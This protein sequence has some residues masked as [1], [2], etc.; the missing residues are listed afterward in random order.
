MIN[1]ARTQRQSWS[2]QPVA[3]P[4]YPTDLLQLLSQLLTKKAATQ[5]TV[6]QPTSPVKAWEPVVDLIG[7]YF[8]GKGADKRQR[9][10]Q[11][12]LGNLLSQATTPVNVPL[13]G[14]GDSSDLSLKDMATGER[15]T[16]QG[17]TRQR[18]RTDQEVVALL[19]GHPAGQRVA[20]R[21]LA[22]QLE[23]RFNP[24][25][26]WV[27]VQG[28]RGTLLQ[29]NNRTGE[30]RSVV[31]QE[32]VPDWHKPGWLDAQRALLGE[33]AKVEK[34]TDAER[35]A[36]G[37]VSRMEEAERLMDKTQ[38]GQTP[39]ILESLGGSSPFASNVLANVA[40]NPERQQYRQAQEDW[41]RSKLRKES[42][43]V[44][45]EEEMDR[46]I[47]VYFP[48]LGDSSE[49]MAQ[50]AKARA[51][52]M[53]AMRQAAGPAYDLKP[54]QPKNPGQNVPGGAPTIDDLLKKY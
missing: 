41:V 11:T 54:R 50:K 14:P 5:S 47:R 25:E 33:K 28:P 51:V 53:G 32:A 46:E 8:L 40:R 31:G 42:G 38:G 20:N 49:V 22:G 7:S 15:L 27:P 19:S 23:R 13:L 30:M 16:G 12:A 29:R 52:A 2:T 4:G 1:Q 36:S 21:F 37:Y 35:M 44:I 3:E 17:L 34:V 24:P 26:R 10:E 6:T 39:G 18:P 9:E 45:A 43:A 48:Q